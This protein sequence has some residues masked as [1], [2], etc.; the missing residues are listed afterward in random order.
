MNVY[1]STVHAI[2]WLRDARRRSP[3]FDQLAGVAVLCAVV[4]FCFGA[5]LAYR[6]ARPSNAIASRSRPRVS[7]MRRLFAP[8]IVVPGEQADRTFVFSNFET[9]S[10]LKPWSLIAAKMDITSDHAAEGKFG[11]RVKYYAHARL[12]SVSARFTMA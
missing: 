8:T 1:R 7:L 4:G 11:A 10:D 3:K 9:I 2:P 12:A 6:E 5:N